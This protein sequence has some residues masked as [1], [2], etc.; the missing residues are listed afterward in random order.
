MPTLRWEDFDDSPAVFEKL[1]TQIIIR[2]HSGAVAIDPRGDDDGID[3]RWDSPDGLS[4]FECKRFTRVRAPQRRQIE[5]SLARA[6]LHHPYRWVLVIPTDP[7]PA[8]DAWFSELRTNYPFILEWLGRTW[9]DERIATYPDLV[10]DISRPAQTAMR[11][12]NQLRARAAKNIVQTASVTG[13]VHFYQTAFSRRTLRIAA[14]LSILIIASIGAI[15]IKQWIPSRPDVASTPPSEGGGPAQENPTPPFGGAPSQPGAVINNPCPL[16]TPDSVERTYGAPPL[17]ITERGFD[18]T[19]GPAL[20]DDVT[21]VQDLTCS[22]ALS[23]S[24]GDLKVR[25]VDLADQPSTRSTLEKIRK[26][27]A[28]NG[29]PLTPVRDCRDECF[30][31]SGWFVARKANRV[32]IFLDV[33]SDVTGPRSLSLEALARQAMAFA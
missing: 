31:T 7:T 14:L 15:A 33:P 27:A 28:K 13:G 18:P 29:K 11:T 5:Q 12:D 8:L 24:A 10:A 21:L 23:S 3:L 6:A 19:V 26:E 16:V 22:F 17:N 32:I 1:A 20:T 4:V 2:E 25:L 30:Q 9:L